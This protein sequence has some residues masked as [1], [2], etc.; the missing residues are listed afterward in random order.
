MPNLPAIPEEG[1][2]DEF[3]ATVFAT[4]DYCGKHHRV[5]VRDEFRNYNTG[6][7]AALVFCPECRKENGSS[8]EMEFGQFEIPDPHGLLYWNFT[9]DESDI[10]GHNE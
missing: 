2:Y 1:D 4:A 7:L 3:K 8:I 9:L 6:K 5:K 10:H